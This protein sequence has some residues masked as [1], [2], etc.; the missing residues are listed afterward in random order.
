M[1]FFSSDPALRL[2]IEK[3][4]SAI[5]IEGLQGLSTE[6]LQPHC[7]RPV[8]LQQ[9]LGLGPAALGLFPGHFSSPLGRSSGRNNLVG[10]GMYQNVI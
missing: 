1:F 8:G 6:G 9:H 10:S 3:S 4:H 7:T 2:P 5:I